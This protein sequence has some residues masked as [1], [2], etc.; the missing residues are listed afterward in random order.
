M[1]ASDREDRRCDGK[2][3]QSP[4]TQGLPLGQNA[5]ATSPRKRWITKPFVR[6]LATNMAFGFSV[7]CFYLL[8]KHLTVSYAATPGM[9]GA[10]T[11]VFGLICVLLVPWLGR[12]VNQIGLGRTLF[13]SQLLMAASSFG[14]VLTN[15]FGAP[16]LILRALQGI[17]TAGIMTAGVA[18]VCELAPS[19]RLGQAMGLA[20]AAS[21]MMN[22]LAPAVAEPI[23]ARFGFVWVFAMAGAAAI[24]GAIAASGLPTVERRTDSSPS[25]SLPRRA[26]P[27]LAALAVT[28][29]G[30]YV[31]VSFLAPL[32][33]Q[34][35]VEAVRGFFIA[36][37][38]SALAIRLGGGNL[39]DR[40]GL[41]RTAVFGMLAYGTFIAGI[42]GVGKLTLIPLGVGFG[43]AHGVL[44][45]A[46]MALL[47]EDAH[48]D[49]RAKLAAFSNG[50]MNLGMFSVLGF[51]QLAN[52]VGLPTVFAASGAMVAFA[53]WLFAPAS[54]AK[55]STLAP[56]QSEAD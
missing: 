32:A 11:G 14:F 18:M 16:M 56:F 23:G 50:V 24:L 5:S 28:G 20:G 42:A 15:G 17:A 2:Q 29:A 22:A 13:L 55:E 38:I 19:D 21:L 36:Y 34:R 30:F 31:A 54:E 26:R 48:P 40:L 46:L 51:G 27:V 10:V 39:T 4:A 44:F 25:L 52:H 45:P 33:L 37:T 8:P 49:D 6:L 47:F 35:G 12:A 7:S 9:V 53:A 3:R 1:L 41:R 43:L